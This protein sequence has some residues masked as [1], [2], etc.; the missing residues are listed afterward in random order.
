MSLLPARF[1]NTDDMP[2]SLGQLIA[3]EIAPNKVDLVDEFETMAFDVYSPARGKFHVIDEADCKQVK[4]AAKASTAA[5]K[6]GASRPLPKAAPPSAQKFKVGDRV[7][8]TFDEGG[9]K[10]GTVT[11]KS[12]SFHGE[13]CCVTD[14]GKFGVFRPDQMA[15]LTPEPAATPVALGDGW[16]EWN[17]GPCPVPAGTLIDTRHRIAFR[18]DKEC[19]SVKAL[20][21]ECAAHSAVWFNDNHKADIIAYRVLA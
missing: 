10:T 20:A 15:H 21:E 14:E 3:R 5:E 9:V 13:W 17:G 11:E 16:I 7:R 18:G 8:L 4:G 2:V 6:V 19:Y 12:V 1:Q